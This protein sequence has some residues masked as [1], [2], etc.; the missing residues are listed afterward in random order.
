MKES[1]PGRE[2]CLGRRPHQVS[3]NPNAFPRWFHL[4]SG[5]VRPWSP[6][7]AGRGSSTCQHADEML[8]AEDQ[9][10]ATCVALGRAD[11]A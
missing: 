2:L 11:I 10:P 3:L 5:E 7:H 6:T 8:G 9:L 1:S 4:P